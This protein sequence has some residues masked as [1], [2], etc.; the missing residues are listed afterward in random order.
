M[1][2]YI[3]QSTYSSYIIQK[4][5]HFGSHCNMHQPLL[6]FPNT[7]IFS[8]PACLRHLSIHATNVKWTSL[9]WGRSLIVLKR[10]CRIQTLRLKSLA[11]VL[12]PC[13]TK[14]D[15]IQGRDSTPAWLPESSCILQAD[16]VDIGNV[17]CIV[18]VPSGALSGMKRGEMELIDILLIKN[19]RVFTW[20]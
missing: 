9:M 13:V 15:G 18:D 19:T 20:K 5:T 1:L 4:H 6:R 11:S 14:S 10:P 12:S 3:L 17:S 2:L 8:R 16:F 7:T